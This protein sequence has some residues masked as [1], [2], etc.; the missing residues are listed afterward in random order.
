MAGDAK[1]R[2]IIE[3]QRRGE[4]AFTSFNADLG[5]LAQR[6]AVV[7]AAAAAALAVVT[8][9]AFENID[10]LAKEA[11]ILSIATD[12][13]AGFQLGAR[14]AGVDNE[15][16]NKALERQRKTIF[17]ASNG[18]S[19]ATRALDLLGLKADDLIKL[20]LD[21]QFLTITDALSKV[22]NATVRGG[23]AADIFGSRNQKLL[24]LI[25]EGRDSLE[26]YVE[27]ADRLGLAVN[28]V[29]AAKIEQA[30]DAFEL[31]KL[32]VQGLGNVIAIELAPAITAISDAFT[33]AGGDVDELGVHVRKVIDGI[34]FGAGL[35]GDAFHG[36]RLI[37]Q[38]VRIGALELGAAI[39]DG[40]ADIVD[41]VN[42]VRQSY[43]DMLDFADE[44]KLAAKTLIAPSTVTPDDVAAASEERVVET[45]NI[46]REIEQSLQLSSEDAQRVF[47]ELAAATKPSEA[48]AAGLARAREEAERTAKATAAV[49]QA[50][51]DVA[52][53]EAPDA[54]SDADK[55]AREKAER[56]AERQR[57]QLEKELEQVREFTLTREE[58]E[59]EATQR[60]L[61][62]LQT[63]YD[64]GLIDLQRYHDLAY[65][66]ARQGAQRLDELEQQSLVAQQRFRQQRLNAIAGMVYAISAITAIGANES[67]KQFELH[68]KISTAEAIVSTLAGVARALKEAPYPINLINAAAVAAFGF[69][70]V[71]RIRST[72]WQGQGGESGGGFAASGG[73]G[74]GASAPEPAIPSLPE[75]DR[76]RAGVLIDLSGAN[77]YGP[78]GAQ[79]FGDL[80]VQLI[81]DGVNDR[82]VEIIAGN[83][84]QAATIRGE[85]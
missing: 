55:R 69:A 24:A 64:Q 53:G 63:S 18:L 85:S 62:I 22:E 9:N 57:E 71:Q 20:G 51:I 74:G 27:Q 21:E 28:R 83:S 16:L 48:L 42:F 54:E 33:N 66:V 45:R 80:V 25:A 2:V 52:G 34:A 50:A 65:E 46:L 4:G 35:V 3:A 59:I 39:V 36:W 26:G 58:I 8:K 31:A 1:A 67:K 44:A 7:G 29:D 5:K 14:L 37:F 77:F 73:G 41:A 61:D 38:G 56:E 84:R 12:K 79:E 17:D 30:N 32:R 72:T 76:G 75:R 68:K 10:A 15:Q 78:G 43:A 49:R 60:R 81:K 6:A 23:I 47:Q 13:L 82:D 70:Q 40:L 19:T 11:D